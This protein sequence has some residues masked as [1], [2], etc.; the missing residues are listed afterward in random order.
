MRAVARGELPGDVDV[1]QLL[2]DLAAGVI[3]RAFVLGREVD[4]DFL[5]RAR[6]PLPRHPRRGRGRHRPAPLTDACAPRE[7]RVSDP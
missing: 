1:E 5:A 2:D 6:R 7:A 3:H 4:T